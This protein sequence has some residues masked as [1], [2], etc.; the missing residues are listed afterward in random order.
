[1]TNSQQAVLP[2]GAGLPS[3]WC[4]PEQSF[5]RTHWKY[6][7]HFG[8]NYVLI[9]GRFHIPTYSNAKGIPGMLDKDT[10]GT[11]H[12]RGR[13][14]L[15]SMEA[16]NGDSLKY[17]WITTSATPPVFREMS[18]LFQPERNCCF[19]CS[20][21]GEMRYQSSRAVLLPAGTFQSLA[22]WE[23]S[24]QP[25]RTTQNNLLDYNLIWMKI[26][27]LRHETTCKNLSNLFLVYNP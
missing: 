19:C 8:Q 12:D 15:R 21:L 17:S 9:R 14:G 22:A 5:K 6:V 13:E 7:K 25:E 2:Q 10:R 24:A 18:D 1:M 20:L 11:A 27:R 3:S 23:F 16:I 26:P 4:Q